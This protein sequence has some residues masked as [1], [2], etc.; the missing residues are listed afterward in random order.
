MTRILLKRCRWLLLWL[1]LPWQLAGAGEMR[2]CSA[3]S[4]F[5]DAALNALILPYR[6]D[7]PQAPPPEVAAAS[8]Q[9]SA[10]VHL[11]VLMG[12]LKYGSVG[13]KDLLAT[14]GHVCD[15][16]E[17][18]ERVTRPG[19]GP[20]TLRPGAAL[21]L[22]WGRLFERDGVL[23][24]Q[25]YLRFLRQGAQGPQPES[26]ALTAQQGS[27]RLNLQLGL[28]AQALAFAPRRIT[29]AEL[30]RVDRE[31]RRAML[32]R[33]QPDEAAPGRSID[34]D[35]ETS[36]PYWV[37]QARGDWMRIQ[38]MQG[39]PGG[40]VRAR[41]P[42]EQGGRYGEPAGWSLQRWLPEL[43]FVDGVAGF[44]RARV[45]GLDAA[46]AAAAA[47]AMERGL[48]RY[49]KAVPQD[50]APEAWGLASALRGWLAW[51]G[52]RREP[53]L[54]LIEKARALMPER[55][56]ARQ[57][58]AGLRLASGPL[59]GASAA[60]WSADLLGALALAPDD[61]QVLANLDRLYSV[62]AARPDWS[63]FAPAA[64][65]ERRELVR[66]ALAARP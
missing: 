8:R 62:Y 24:V 7:G 51:Q 18:L 23:H 40:W 15:V 55:A 13:A 11:E 52:G 33:E 2:P 43:A 53:A 46:A 28:P 25:S 1:L 50:L 9:I 10:L 45:G 19:G 61:R 6:F 4:V 48:A 56:A 37:T 47:L 44:L 3:A 38:P 16:D 54:A 64:L 66:E 22:V 59:N 57:L 14:P 31:F 58:A 32:V 5:E 65:Q 39:G 35:P 30:A 21:I 36:F 41:V 26:L 63:P 20:G 29:R 60:R 27:T 12:L 17:V 42:D 34:F 49:E